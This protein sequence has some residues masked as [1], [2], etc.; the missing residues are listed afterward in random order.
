MSGIAFLHIFSLGLP[1]DAPC[2]NKENI[3]ESQQRTSHWK[4]RNIKLNTKLFNGFLKKFGIA[5]KLCLTL[6]P[7]EAVFWS[8]AGYKEV[9]FMVSVLI[10]KL[11]L[12]IC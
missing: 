8:G 6:Y 1:T 9:V 10:S 5:I 11:N 7:V 4:R 3:P 12:S 2:S